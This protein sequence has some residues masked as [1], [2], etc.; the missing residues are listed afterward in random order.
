MIAHLFEGKVDPAA[1]REYG[2][3]QI[4]I[5]DSS[6]LFRD[7]SNLSTIWMSHG[8]HLT[9][10]PSNFSIIAKTENSPIAA[11]RNQEKNIFGIQFHPEVVHTEFG[12]K[13]LDNFLQSICH[14]KK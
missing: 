10:I 1:R 14:L 9:A 3:A 5:L 4:E 12:V 7:I 8:D 11:I 6:D 2:R 13:I